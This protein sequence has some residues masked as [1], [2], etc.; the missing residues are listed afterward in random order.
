MHYSSIDPSYASTWVAK[1]RNVIGA[2]EAGTL[3]FRSGASTSLSSRWVSRN[4]LSLG[5]WRQFFDAPPYRK[6]FGTAEETKWKY[7]LPITTEGVIA[8]AL[9]KSYISALPEGERN[10]V[11]DSLRNILE[12]E[13]KT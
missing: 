10:Q 7:I 12:T 1:A 6:F 3:Q 5:L 4:N 13:Q 2:R 8:R 11:A 9:S